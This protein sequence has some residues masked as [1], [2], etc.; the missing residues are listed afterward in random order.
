MSSLVLFLVALLSIAFGG[1]QSLRYTLSLDGKSVG[2]RDVTVR[3]L[4]SGTGEV[5]ILE[6]W[7]E[8]NA[9]VAG[10][11]ITWRNRATAKAGVG[12]PGFTS[13]LDENG[14]LREVQARV[15][16]DRR[17]QVT[18]VE[19]GETKTWTLRGGEVTLSS[20][21]LLDPQRRLLLTDGR[22]AASLLM[23]EVGNV[24]TGAV[25]DLGEG[26]VKVAGQD[27]DVH[28]W[29]FTPDTGRIELAWTADGLLVSYQMAW[30]GRRLTGV[31]DALPPPP[32]FGEIQIAPGLGGGF[33]EEKL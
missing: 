18:V 29:G 7:T 17:W 12:A 14:T 8:I 4:P 26:T 11:P 30:M 16:P 25:E 20:L 28:R 24:L 5:R 23:A 13:S 10:A 1:E 6:T 21:D 32:E 2:H 31:L 22:D 15:L 9:S 3:Y 33:E 27:V 19:A